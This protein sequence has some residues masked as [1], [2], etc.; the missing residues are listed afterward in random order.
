MQ[1]SEQEETTSHE[2]FMRAALDEARLAAQMGEV[3]IGAVV[4]REGEI[5]A[6]AHNVRE[7]DDDPSSH[8]EFSAIMA[9]SR[10][11]GRWRLSDCIVYVTLEPCLMCAGLMINA[12]IGACIY[13]APDPKG[14]ALGSLYAVNDD[15]RLNHRFAVIPGV[16][17]DECAGV[18]KSFF[19]TMRAS[20]KAAMR[21][22]APAAPVQEG[23]PTDAAPEALRD[24]AGA[25]PADAGAA[26]DAADAYER[27]ERVHL[28]KRDRDRARTTGAPRAVRAA[29][30]PAAS[31][32]FVLAIDSFK[33][34]ATSDQVERWFEEGV[35]RAC[36]SARVECVLLAD[37]GE[38]TVAAASRALD[39]TMR[40]VAV[41]DPFGRVIEAEYLLTHDGEAIIEASAAAGVEFSGCTHDEALRASSYGVGELVRDA[42]R[43]GASRI[44]VG[45]G[46]SATSD[47][48]T[49]L[50]SALGARV[51]DARG[52]EVPP[53]L[54]GLAHVASVE[55]APAIE[56]LGKTELIALVDVENPLVGKR[57][58][59]R[60]FGPQKGLADLPTPRG[61]CATLFD[62]L[63]RD[64]ISYASKLDDA[65]VACAGAGRQEGE[66]R[67]RTVSGVP[68]AG[69]AG[70]LGAAL[71]ACGAKLVSGAEALLDLLD[72]DELLADADVV[73]TGEGRID[74]QTAAGKGPAI[75]A[76]RA[77]RA[78]KPV[79]A[80]AGGRSMNL[81]AVYRAGVDAV[82]PVLRAPMPLDRALSAEE[83]RRNLVC[84]GET[85]ARMLSMRRLR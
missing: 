57:G 62:Q 7:R 19:A 11:L 13:G 82:L 17:E 71:L 76:R 26:G 27:A 32:S 43:A 9:A 69:A 51:L 25:L 60:V 8:A 42:V 4:V 45:L 84:A 29:M 64:M 85:V 40:A 66:R 78:G 56:A 33:E 80:V 48:G 28:E 67:F 73:V 31:L 24:A 14:G 59:V 21:A 72:F 1:L 35:R 53:G 70:G 79:V 34:S 49:G 44:Y 63:D 30:P 54:E 38:G 3:P 10:K 12:R 47:G 61:D 68:G 36:P 77:A 15:A 46:G 6:R 16:L 2:R 18:L 22:E 83:T 39:G 65:R 58:A 5:I 41:S 37:G 20:R 52:R 74:E 81:D 55:L 50:L 75:V 23:A